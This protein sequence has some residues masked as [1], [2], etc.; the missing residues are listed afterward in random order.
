MILFENNKQIEELAAWLDS[1]IIE[2][3]NKYPNSEYL[4]EIRNFKDMYILPWME[5]HLLTGIEVDIQYD[6]FIKNTILD[7]VN[8]I[9]K[10]SGD[11][12]NKIK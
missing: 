2:F 4:K 3:K 6:K 7:I 12:N 11:I 9:E 1:K 8:D 10:T 5:K